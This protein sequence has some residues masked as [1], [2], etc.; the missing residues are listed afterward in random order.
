MK[1]FRQI[2]LES[3]DSENVPG[4]PLT[5][6]RHLE[7]EVL[8]DGHEG[9]GRSAKFL[10]DVHNHLLG[11]KT[12]T[13]VSTKYDGAP[14]VVYGQHPQ[15]GKF[16]VASK[17]AFNKD[18]KIN[19]T[20][21]DIER[22]HGHAP[23]LVAKLKEGLKNLPKIMPHSG[24]VYQ[25]DFMYGKGD[26]AKENGKTS[27]T[28]NTIT[29]KTPGNSAEGKK[30]ANSEIGFVTHTEYKGKG[31]LENMSATPLS[32]EKR[33]K[34]REHP[35]VNHID[36]TEK[37]NTNNYTPE[38]QKQ[39]ENHREN[40]RRV[41]QSIKPEAFD[42]IKGHGAD[43]E[44]HVND[45]VRKEGKPSFAGYVSHLQDKHEKEIGKLKTQKAI[46]IKKRAFS[47]KLQHINQNKE[48]FSKIL[49]LHNHLQKAKDVLTHVMA[50]NSPYEH[51]IGDQPAA[52]EGAVAVNKDG[53]MT[54]FVDRSGFA[55]DNLNKGKFQTPAKAPVTTPTKAPVTES[56]NEEDSDVHHVT[57]F[58]RAQPPTIGH[59]LVVDKVKG[60][61]DKIGATH[62]IV[63]SHSH[64]ANNPLTPEQKLKHAK[65]SFPGV[66]ISTSSTEHPS[67][68]HHLAKLHSQ[69]VTHAHV[70]V[71]QDRVE[72]FKKL[73]NQYNG[74]SGPH[75]YYNFKGINVVSA[76]ERDPDAE[77]TA[78]ISGTKMRK[79]AIAGDRET[80]HGG[81]PDTMT[82][83]Q[84][85]EMMDDV[86]GGIKKFPSKKPKLTKTIKESV[87][88][89]MLR[90]NHI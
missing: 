26:T 76:G 29:Y 38:E 58:M 48:H 88:N 5:H 9:V 56:L 31:G 62:S 54:K 61:A 50:K 85:N 70:V 74:V 3:V 71:G 10:N 37:V 6:L 45:Q 87:I 7:D 19:Y 20:D 12:S 90:G 73:L 86:V 81:A 80:F 24:G 77:G 57:T 59:K 60:E 67:I 82:P 16:F 17:S 64:D 84:K 44:A 8:Y 46:D 34:F 27:F 28:P 33:A 41:Y 75:G 4:K 53:D 25:G 15:T 11:K 68:L 69:G 47:E 13:H 1:S 49:E 21:E 43:L 35:D 79:A 66:N 22:N 63:L 2:I 89:F 23:G 42:A 55:R 32:A 18:P 52:P 30:I 14:S 36:P 72:G 40:A 39:F 51:T 78:G 65:L 83:K